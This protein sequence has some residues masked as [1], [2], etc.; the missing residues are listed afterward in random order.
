MRVCHNYA[1]TK[2]LCGYISFEGVVCGRQVPREQL[3]D[4]FKYTVEVD[5]R[6]QSVEL[7]RAEQ[8]V[9]GGGAFSSRI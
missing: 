7:G 9:L 4:P 8:R 1:S 6:V 5:L 3:G 2:T